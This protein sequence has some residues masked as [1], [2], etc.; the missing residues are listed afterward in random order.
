[1]S[2]L[3]FYQLV[4]VLPTGTYMKLKRTYANLSF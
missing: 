2:P 1:M 3:D 4:K